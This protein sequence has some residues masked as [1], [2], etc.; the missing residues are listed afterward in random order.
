MVA[1]ASQPKVVKSEAQRQQEAVQ[2]AITEEIRLRLIAADCS[3]MDGILE[4]AANYTVRDWHLRNGKLIEAADEHFTYHMSMFNQGKWQGATAMS[5]QM[6]YAAYQTAE[7]AA[8]EVIAV[9]NDKR[10]ACMSRLD[11]YKRGDYDL[12]R[13]DPVMAAQIQD[14]KSDRSIRDEKL[15]LQQAIIKDAPRAGRSMY[16]VEK[17]WAKRG[18]ERGKVAIMV[19]QWPNEV[20]HGSCKNESVVIGCKWGS[21]KE[22]K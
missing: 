10:A 14:L 19:A 12:K 7:R 16:Q 11:A 8:Q 20:Y 2:F 22:L 15:K 1:C 5:Q 13:I 18:C 3:Q 4:A 17:M 9:E 6:V 21:C